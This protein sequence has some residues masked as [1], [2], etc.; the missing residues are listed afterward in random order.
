MMAELSL[1]TTVMQSEI[2]ERSCT[3][4]KQYFMYDG[5]F[6]CKLWVE[7]KKGKELL[8]EAIFA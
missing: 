8:S 5:S 7:Y 4:T 2:H 3:D 1:R 6:L